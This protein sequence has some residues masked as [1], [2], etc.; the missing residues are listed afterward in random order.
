MN[1]DSKNLLAAQRYAE[2][3]IEFGKD[4]KLSYVSIASDIAFVLTVLNRS[5]DLYESLINPLI[6]ITDK[7]AVIDAVFETNVDVLIKNFLKLLVEK[8]RFG[9]IYEISD[10]FNSMLDDINEIARVEVVSA[11]ELNDSEKSR[12]SDKLTE[13]LKKQIN[14]KYN[15][16]SSVIAGLVIKMGDDIID[17]SLAHKL[18]NF[19]MA[20]IK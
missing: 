19:K 20:L 15:I 4:G 12:I 16:D 6:S 18:E 1:N 11:V 14:I 17:M 9:L 13:K 8:N 3:L 5:K 7:E 10:S 2:A